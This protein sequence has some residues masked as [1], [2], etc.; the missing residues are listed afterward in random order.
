MNLLSTPSAASAARK[1]KVRLALALT[2]A[3]ALAACSSS[4]DSDPAVS[5]STVVQ[6]LTVD[7]TGQTVVITLG[8]FGGTITPASVEASAGQSAT[9]VT[10]NGD[11]AV[12]G[13]DSIVSPDHQV[14]FVGVGG[15]SADWRPVETSDGRNPLFAITAATQDTSD[16]VLGGDTIT[17]EFHSGPRVLESEAEDLAN[18]TLSVEGV[19]LDLTGSSVVLDNATQTAQ[20]TLG[21]LANLHSNFTLSAT[22][23][24]VAATS[25]STNALT[26]FATGDAVAPALE[27]GTPVVQHLDP[28]ASGDEFGRVLVF[29]FDEPI[30]PVFGAVASSF[31]V[32]DHVNAQGVTVPTNVELVSGDDTQ[33][34]VTFSRPVVPGLDQIALN[35]LTDAH[36]NEIVPLNAAIT[37][38]STVANA[39][40]TVDFITVE[41]VGNDRVVAT[42]SQALDPDTA[43][44]DDR[45]AFTVGGIGL[46]DLST[47]SMSYDLFTRTLT[48]DLDFDVANG[49]TGDLS[50]VGGVDVDGETF[51]VA[52]TQ[53]L[54]AGDAGAPSVSSVTQN[55][56]ADV[57]GQT[58]D[59]VF[60]E[61]VDPTT[62]A[63]TANYTF[64]P[65]LVVSGASVLAG[66]I[67]RLQTADVA[68]PGDY[69]L[70]I[71][72]A[73]SDPAGNDLGAPFGPASFVS[74]DTTAPQT[75]A[76]SGTAVEGAAN[77]RITVLFNDDMVPAEVEDS[78]N[79]TVES[80]VGTPVDVT[81]ATISYSAAAGSAT[82]TLEGGSPT[83]LIRTDDLQVAFT[84]MRDLGGNTIAPDAFSAT[85]LGETNRP[86]ME[87]AFVV[88][89]GAGDE[90]TLR[91]SEP[92]RRLTD[93]FDAVANPAGVRYTA[94]DLGTASPVAPQSATELDGGLGVRLTF[95]DPVDAA[96]TIDVI[97]LVDLAGNVL[98]PVT[99]AAL[100]VEAV[101]EPAIGSSTV[102]ATRGTSNDT[103]QVVFGESMS[104]WG[105]TSPDSYTFGVSAGASLD[106]E[107]DDAEFD[108]DGNDTVTITFGAAS[109]F[110]LDSGTNYEVGLAVAPT[111]PLRTRFGVELTA[112]AVSGALAVAGDN[113]AGPDPA[114]CAAIL[115]PAAA[116]S[117]FVIFDESVDATAAQVATSYDLDGVVATSATLVDPRVVR[118]TFVGS[119]VGVGQVLTA[120]A[121]VVDTAGNAPT[122]ALALS[123]TSDAVIPTVQSATAVITPGLAGDYVDVTFDEA[124]DPTTAGDSGNYALTTTSGDLRL[125]AVLYDSDGNTARL[126]VEDMPEADTITVSVDGIS[127]FAGNTF[128]GPS[129]TPAVASGDAVAP[130]FSSAFAHLW[131]DA[132][133]A[134]VDVRFSE[135]I[136]YGFAATPGNWSTSGTATVTGAQ[137]IGFDH[138]RL[139]LTEAMGATDTLS[140]G[141]GLVDWAGNAA[142]QLSI[143]PVD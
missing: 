5:A 118:V 55:R 93:L 20:F 92:M 100:D 25:V 104:R 54:A 89:G 39:F 124:V 137:V 7:P 64:A 116:D 122:G 130:S 141:A 12:I 134:T 70:T 97:G 85:V 76:L 133:G 78:A 29:D 62:A 129:A 120:A 31:S 114:A 48:I 8:G 63:D 73:V 16:L 111:D 98:F 113:G 57:T 115:D 103:I 4:G 107:L 53:V 102:T 105:I 90:V 106:S 52:A 84:G 86:A 22:I 61:D 109:G 1:T 46:V 42:T 58:L 139:T 21:S 132:T 49:T 131:V 99:G 35:G 81:G 18:W 38:G 10:M 83:S 143:D 138:V 128:A 6:N 2:A 108:F 45:W 50:S 75:L 79:W 117:A 33:V 112:P 13:F 119:T 65:A 71:A 56:V 140:I 91:F 3:A 30:S 24:T 43:A 136:D 41:G 82:V 19:N 15:V 40:V 88:S 44:N 11:T 77:D 14:R 60:S 110:N 125:L 87:A 34:R 101:T 67:V 28:A 26:G 36:G 142:G 68:L 127:D 51:S 121:S 80:P 123:V 9:T 72:Q 96:G 74:T 32:V 27:G 135:D 23:G 66:N 37:A 59:V 47:Q 94:T 95:T 69:T 126:L 17:V